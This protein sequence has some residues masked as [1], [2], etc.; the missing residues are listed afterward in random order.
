MMICVQVVLIK[1]VWGKENCKIRVGKQKKPSKGVVSGKTPSQP[2]ATGNSGVEV[3]PHSLPG[4][5]AKEL[6]F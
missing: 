2:H 4:L 5:K 1:K 3:T 6:G